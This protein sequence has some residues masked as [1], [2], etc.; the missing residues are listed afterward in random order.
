MPIGLRRAI[1]IEPRHFESIFNA[2][3]DQG[4]AAGDCVISPTVMM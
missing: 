1:V 2:E 4:D 3:E